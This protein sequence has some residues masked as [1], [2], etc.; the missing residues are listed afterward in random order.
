ML[1]VISW[2]ALIIALVGIF[3]AICDTSDAA[4][5]RAKED[6]EKRK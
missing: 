3:F 6:A 1:E 4:A 5:K 2:P